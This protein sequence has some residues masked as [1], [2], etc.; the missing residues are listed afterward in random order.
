MLTLNGA[1]S[2]PKYIQLGNGRSLDFSGRS[3]V[4]GIVNC[5]TDSFYTDSRAGTKAAAVELARRMIE[6]GADILDIGGESTRPGSDSI[7]A[8][9]EAD[10][11]VPVIEEIR[12]FCD[13]PISIDT[14]KADVAKLALDAGAD[15]VNDI[16][17]MRADA[18]MCPL[19]ASRRCAVVLM[20]MR[21][22]PKTMQKDPSY[23]DAVKEVVDELAG[24]ADSAVAA[25]VDRDKIMV[26]PGIGFGKRLNDNLRL[27]K[28]I[29][30]MHG[31]G[32]P[33]LI[34]LSRKSFIETLLGLPVE[35]RLAA[36]LAA[37]AYVA[38]NGAEIIRVHDV[39][40][41]VHLSKVLAAI[42]TA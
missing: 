29:D 25:G 35:E 7:P 11:V 31:L 32:Y 14:Q 5:T 17:A 30:A 28:H 3:L 23:V 13:L 9:E 24:F 10:R 42:Q 33:V 4:M 39:R 19:V 22:T 27:L 2:P 36:S 1:F 12:G 34:G 20:H 6:A 41:T 40:E 37:E 26:D 18:D 8:D 15:I 16:S 21:G 38:L